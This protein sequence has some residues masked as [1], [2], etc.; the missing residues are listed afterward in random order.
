ML[1]LLTNLTWM[2][3][4]DIMLITF[5]VYQLF[6]LFHRTKG[7]RILIG[8]A[9]LAIIYIMV[10]SWGLFLSTWVFQVF[11]QAFIILIIIVFQPEIRE[12]LE[13]V[14]LLNFLQG[15]KN[16][17]SDT[18][19]IEAV[20][21]AV[22]SMA[23]RR[24]GAIIV[25]KQKD[26]LK[27]LIR[28][29][30]QFDGEISEPIL[31]SIFQKSSSIHDGAILIDG[32]RI[33]TVAG[34]LPM[35]ERENLPNH[36]GSRHRA[37]LGLSEKSDAFIIVVSEETGD[38]SVVQHEKIRKIKDMRLLY[39]LI[40]E[41]S[42]QRRKEKDSLIKSFFSTLF[43]QDWPKKA[44]AFLLVFVLWA[45]LAGQQNYSENLLV[46]IE[47]TRIPTTMELVSPPKSA[48]I[49]IKGLRKLV[50][51]LKAEDLRIELDVSLSQWGRRTY[52]ISEEE[53]NLPAGIQLEYID[54]SVL[55]LDFR[56]KNAS[57][58]GTSE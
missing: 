50:S 40:Q 31:L 20:S 43:I 49:F 5:V 1:N 57:E 35:T 41:H 42:A 15:K 55:R 9:F 53:I 14:N 36:Y 11:W 27:D 28:G 33:K 8:L 38:V 32:G 2:D 29:S 21:R 45:S 18:S 7:F 22:F 6:I 12:V 26:D 39:S 16:H 46:P 52:Y 30:I 23:E 24:I 13:K 34:Y 47:Y 17:S 10:R 54:P 44:T 25:F 48:K 58:K 4:V 51:S 3:F 56:I 19:K 37:C